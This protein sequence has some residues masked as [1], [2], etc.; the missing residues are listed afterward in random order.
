M[1]VVNIWGGPGSGKTTLAY[2]LTYICKKAGLRAEFVGEAARE[3]HIYDSTPGIIP[4][5]LLDNQILLAGQQ[6]E[7]IVR[8]RR[9]N[10]QV[11]ISDSPVQQ[12][13]LYCT[14]P[15]HTRLLTPLVFSLQNELK[16]INIFANREPGTF[17]AESRVQRNEAEAAAFDEKVRSLAPSMQFE[18]HWG[19]EF[20]L[21]QMLIR[22]L[23]DEL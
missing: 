15:S 4:P 7:R 3:E 8:L 19:S 20:S 10:F 22:R 23:Q 6:Y 18:A 2:Y 16:S 21:G 14:N 12:G 13:V 1:I 5:P 17:D 11:A 9:H